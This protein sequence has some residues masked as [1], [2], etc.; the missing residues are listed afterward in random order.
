TGVGTANPL[1]NTFHRFAECLLHG[2]SGVRSVAAFDVS[3]HPSQIAGQIDSIPCPPDMAPEGFT[4]LQPLEQLVTSCANSSLRDAGWW[5]ARG[6]VRLGLVLGI[7]AEW[8]LLWET[9]GL[10]GGN[11]IRH[12]ELDT[13]SL[14]E[15]TRQRLGL[16]GPVACV[17][18]ACA[19]GNHALA[20]AR[21]WLQ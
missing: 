15:R 9:D 1:G 4:A 7:G 10:P 2:Q 17:S 13:T 18:A 14:V 6:D 19:S 16:S 5:E 3:Q 20:Q 12:P 8:A 21:R 11:R